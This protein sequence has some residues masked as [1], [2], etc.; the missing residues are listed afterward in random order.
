[1]WVVVHM[2]YARRVDLSGRELVAE[3]FKETPEGHTGG[4]L[5]VVPAY[6]GYLAAN[7]LTAQTRGWLPGQG[8]PNDFHRQS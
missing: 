1:M 8:Q 5:N 3:E 7:L 4:S 2:T 6:I